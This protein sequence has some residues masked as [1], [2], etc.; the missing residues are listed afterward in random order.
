MLAA[1]SRRVSCCL[2]YTRA[3]CRTCKF[4]TATGVRKT[5]LCSRIRGTQGKGLMP[6]GTSRFTRASTGETIAHFMGCSTFSEYTVVPE[7]AL[8]VVP[9]DVPLARVCLLGCG[10]T[11]G[12]GAVLNTA[13]VEEGAASAAVFG[14]G[15]VGLA[16]ILG[17]RKRGVKKILAIDVNPAKFAAAT[18]LGGPAVVCVNPRDYPGRKIS[19]VVVELTTEDGWGGAHYTFECVG[20]VELMRAALEA[21]HRAWGVSVIIGVAP[22]GTEIATRPFQLVTGVCVC[23]FGARLCQHALC[24]ARLRHVVNIIARE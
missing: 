5:N 3:E 6:D 7:I 13:D 2:S 14:L 8:A 22:A 20:S 23:M 9:R 1:Y 10:V 24:R 11:T 4:C 17:L 19:E 18:D 16:V 12:F 15:A 21:S